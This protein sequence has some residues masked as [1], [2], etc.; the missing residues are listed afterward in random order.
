[1]ARPPRGVTTTEYALILGVLAALMYGTYL[2]LGSSL[3]S[4]ANGIDSTLTMASHGAAA[5]QSTPKP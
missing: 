2:A 3:G 5:S 4:L 1:M